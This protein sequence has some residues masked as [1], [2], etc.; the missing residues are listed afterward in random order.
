ML[1]AYFLQLPYYLYQQMIDYFLIYAWRFLY[2][3]F[4]YLFLIN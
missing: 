3:Y 4:G 2:I 1:L